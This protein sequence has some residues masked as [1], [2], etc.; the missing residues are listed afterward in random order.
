M[1]IEIVE[2]NIALT[3]ATVEMIENRLNAALGRF[4]SHIRTVTITIED[5]NGPKGGIDKTVR[6]AVSGRNSAE[7]F[8]LSDCDKS[9]IVAVGR[10]ADRAAR[11]FSRQLQRSNERTI[12]TRQ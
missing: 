7:Q 2:R 5:D 11:T 4:D 6:L 12:P 9:L 1:R 8:N 10:V 3:P